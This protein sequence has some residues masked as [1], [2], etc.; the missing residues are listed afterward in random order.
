MAIKLLFVPFNSLKSTI[1]TNFCNPEIPGLGCR[2]SQDSGWAKTTPGIANTNYYITGKQHYHRQHCQA[3]FISFQQQYSTS[4]RIQN[5]SNNNA[6]LGETYKLTFIPA[7][8]SFLIWCLEYSFRALE[9]ISS[10]TLR[11]AAILL[12]TSFNCNKH[13]SVIIDHQ[14]LNSSSIITI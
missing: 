11:E 8:K 14:W 3:K 2:Q 5:R 9:Q 10:K 13:Q 12:D 6:I 1:L 4:N 7:R